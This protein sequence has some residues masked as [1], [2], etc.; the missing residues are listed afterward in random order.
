MGRPEI[1]RRGSC[2]LRWPTPWW[3]F[4]A[5]AERGSDTRSDFVRR[6]PLHRIVVHARRAS[7][8]HPAKDAYHAEPQIDATDN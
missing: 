4:S 3:N 1:E 5:L 6:S 8:Y 2:T 7:G